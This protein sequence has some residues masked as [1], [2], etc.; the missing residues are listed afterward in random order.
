MGFIPIFISLG[1]FV[2]LFVMLVNYNLNSKKKLY[3]FRLVSL[4]K[5]VSEAYPAIPVGDDV[6]LKALEHQFREA[7]KQSISSH[8]A[9]VDTKI[10]S[11]FAACKMARFQYQRL[12]DTKPY[13][14]VAKLFG[15]E[16]I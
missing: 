12:K 5:I 15:H 4:K 3:F 2:F 1:G 11:Q 7:K 10:D 14:F 9:S 8:D 16:D 6:E 13:F